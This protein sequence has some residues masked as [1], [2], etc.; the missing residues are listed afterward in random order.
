MFVW[1]ITNLSERNDARWRHDLD[2]RT[3]KV[4]T[5]TMVNTMS[6][7]MTLSGLS[8]P[9]VGIFQYSCVLWLT[10]EMP[11]TQ[12]HIYSKKSQHLNQ[13]QVVEITNDWNAFFITDITFVLKFCVFASRG[14]FRILSLFKLSDCFIAYLLFW[15]YSCPRHT[16][17]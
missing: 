9:Q 10:T 1:I 13:W 4:M 6:M 7:T 8:R 15:S 14:S 5:Y 3:Y 16:I 11:P 12:T 17:F 2:A